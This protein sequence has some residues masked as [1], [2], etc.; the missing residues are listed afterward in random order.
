[1]EATPQATQ[2]EITVESLALIK[3]QRPEV[4]YFNELLIQYPH[5]RRGQIRQVVPDNMVVVHSEPIQ[6]TGSYDIPLQPVSP[7]WV[8]DYVSKQS[9]RKDYEDSFQKYERELKVPY[10][11]LYYPDAQDLALLRLRTRKYATVRNNAAERLEIPELDLEM[12]LKDGWVR[13]WYK[14][15]LLPLPA[16]LQGQLQETRRQLRLAERQTR[17]AEH[18]ARQAQEQ[19]RQAQADAERQRQQTERLLAQLRALGIEPKQ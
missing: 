16:E 19:A 5:G 8:L 15:E 10:C 4:Q 3:A 7:L 2:R 1:M 13:F 6:A 12:A 11:L 14:G 18:Q 17:Q 9:K